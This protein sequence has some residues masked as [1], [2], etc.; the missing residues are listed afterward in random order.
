MKALVENSTRVT[1]SDIMKMCQKF[2]TTLLSLG[3][4]NLNFHGNIQD[5]SF[6]STN[7][8]F[9][10]KRLWFICFWCER[11]RAHLYFNHT[12]QLACRVCYRLAYTC[13]VKHRNKDYEFQ[14][15]YENQRKKVKEKLDNK[16]LKNV[17]KQDLK[18]KLM[19]INQ[20]ETYGLSPLFTQKR[21]RKA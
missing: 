14:K 4:I 19:K 15:R 8:N 18:H 12:Y 10:G 3:S 2:K 20:R 9:G 11:R 1:V 21:S 17:T 7:T 16:F 13:Q 6:S 5:V